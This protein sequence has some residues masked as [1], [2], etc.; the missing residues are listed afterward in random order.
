M[1]KYFIPFDIETIPQPFES[2]DESQQEY[3]IRGASTQEEIERRKYEMAL[4]PITGK[5]ITI[6][7]KVIE[8]ETDK[9][10][11][12]NYKIVSSG[13]LIVDTDMEDE[14][15][16]I[17]QEY[18]TDLYLFTSERKI[19]KTFWDILNKYK[20]STLISFNGRNFDAPYIQLRSALLKVSPSRNLMEGTKFNYQ[21]HIDLMDEL[22]FY[23]GAQYG[24]TRRYNFDFYSR[25]FGLES[26]KA[27]GVDGAN[28]HEYFAIKD[29]KTI[30]DYC[31]RDVEATWKLYL[32]IKDY[33]FI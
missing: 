32:R 4:S 29:Y 25:A 20:N 24:A 30:A 16:P 1:T 33:L 8:Q 15:E 28:V 6:G 9:Y 17:K 27:K 21:N 10:N 23:S 11:D 19:L 2:L 22:T 7:L 13:A 12:V 26:P 31:M 14:D 5:I 18:G 3:L